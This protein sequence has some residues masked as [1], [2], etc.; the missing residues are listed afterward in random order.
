MEADVSLVV[1]YG[2][3]KPNYAYLRHRN[4]SMT[5]IVRRQYE[6]AELLRHDISRRTPR[7][8]IYEVPFIVEPVEMG[9]VPEA[10]IEALSKKRLRPAIFKE[11]VE[12]TF[13][14]PDLRAETVYRIFGSFIT[15]RSIRYYPSIR[16][17][18]SSGREIGFTGEG[19]RLYGS[20]VLTLAVP[21]DHVYR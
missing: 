8:G 10:V 12:Y 13:M 11:A 19:Q 16:I 6:E 20:A 7:D 21:V 17:V 9:G 15:M 18:R 14:I 5:P 4:F 3:D 1:D 2:T